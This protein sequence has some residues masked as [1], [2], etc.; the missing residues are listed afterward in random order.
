VI[1]GW[2]RRLA[3]HT[4][5]TVWYA[6]ALL[7]VLAVYAVLVFA[8]LER[9]LWQQLDARLH[10]AAESQ[11]AAL[12]AVWTPAGP[13]DISRLVS[14]DDDPWIEVWTRD[15]RLL[16]RSSRASRQPLTDVPAPSETR[17]RSAVVAGRH[18]RVRDETGRIAGQPVYL[19]A[20][21]SEER[22]REALAEL[23][24]LMGMGLPLAV[25]AAALGG[26]RLARRAL[27]PVDR[28]AD[29]VRVI[30]AERLA[31]RL[32]VENPSDEIGR[33]ATVV[34]DTLARLE[35][36]FE[37]MRRFTADASHELRTPLT[38]IRTV[39]EVSL[40]EPREA[41]AYREVIGSMLEEVDRLTR[42]VDTML[43]LSRAEAGY[44]PVTRE[45]TDI[46]AVAADVA[47][48]LDVL[49]DEKGQHLA[50]HADRPA[51]AM[52]DRV[53]LRLALVN[54]VDNAIRHNPPGCDIDV[55]VRGGP[56]GAVVEIEDRGCG[57]AA[58]HHRKL[59][60][61]FYRVDV[62]R[63]RGDGGAGLGLSIARWAVE[64][65]NGSIE[66]V[67]EE[68][69]GSTFRILMPAANAAAAPA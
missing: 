13:G 58:T 61:R 51:W 17:F 57:I 20:V 30:T 44:I 14:D 54:L 29:R 7:A 2:W 42:L 6:A 53:V 65:Q 11:E 37:Q 5:L 38:A 63:S 28:M 62:A 39:G 35:Q 60:D 67:S 46:S 68:G 25:G 55:R 12:Q 4:R 15:G 69:R 31:D 50:V 64:V 49:A 66:V 8:F 43:L 48:Q 19:R 41:P 33:L 16:Y 24:L 3:L 1:A 22:L 10:E 18:V 23:L 36:S 59:F 21:E 56:D 34:N 52:A 9:S 27:S 40:R 45:P 32:P 47:A 26:A